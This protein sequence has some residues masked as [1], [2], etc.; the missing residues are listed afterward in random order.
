VSLWV[1]F[2]F[3]WKIQLFV[4]WYRNSQNQLTLISIKNAFIITNRFQ[5]SYLDLVKTFLSAA[6]M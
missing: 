3:V 4:P 2:D 5:Y 1:P 6:R